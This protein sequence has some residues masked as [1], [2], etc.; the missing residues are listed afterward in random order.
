MPFYHM[1]LH[2][3]VQQQSSQLLPI[4][5]QVDNPVLLPQLADSHNLPTPP[6]HRQSESRG[7]PVVLELQAPAK[8]VLCVM[9][10]RFATAHQTAAGMF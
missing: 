3:R 2:K 8:F 5:L 1:H 6:C 7:V 4:T 9:C 10:K